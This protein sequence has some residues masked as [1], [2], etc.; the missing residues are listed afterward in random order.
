M[1]DNRDFIEFELVEPLL[2][3]K[4]ESAWHTQGA[5]GLRYP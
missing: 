1:T 3:K 2:I 4:R 5:Y